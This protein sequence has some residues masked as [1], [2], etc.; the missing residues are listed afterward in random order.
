M[1][2]GGAAAQSKMVRD[3]KRSAL[4]F[5]IIESL[6]ICFVYETISALYYDACN[7]LMN[8]AR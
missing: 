2:G 1:L 8:S 3:D 7:A 6:S 5:G 4:Y